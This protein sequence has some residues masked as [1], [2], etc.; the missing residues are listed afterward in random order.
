LKCVNEGGVNFGVSEK[1][2]GLLRGIKRRHIVAMLKG[3][4]KQSKTKL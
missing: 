2:V 4:L 3:M 1:N